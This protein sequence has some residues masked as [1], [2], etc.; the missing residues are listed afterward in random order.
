MAA[1]YFQPRG[2]FYS[3]RGRIHIVLFDRAAQRTTETD[4]D[5]EVN[6]TLPCDVRMCAWR[7]DEDAP[8][9]CLQRTC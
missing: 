5:E 8:G 2:H 1:Q 7:T 3:M 4:G 6:K 9:W